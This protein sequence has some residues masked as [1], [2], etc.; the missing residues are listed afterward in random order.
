MF[1]VEHDELLRTY[2][3]PDVLTFDSPQ[4]PAVTGVAPISEVLDVGEVVVNEMATQPFGHGI[5]GDTDVDLV[6]G[7]FPQVQADGVSRME[8]RERAQV[9]VSHRDR[10]AEAMLC[11]PLRHRLITNPLGQ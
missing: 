7:A 8:T 4:G 9:A 10:L 11:G 3:F 1:G 2:G 5:S 6:L